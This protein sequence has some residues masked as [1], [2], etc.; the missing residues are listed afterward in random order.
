[1]QRFWNALGGLK[2]F[3]GGGEGWPV[4][5]GGVSLVVPCFA[6]VWVKVTHSVALILWSPASF[7]M[8]SSLVVCLLGGVHS[9]SV[10]GCCQWL[11]LS[12]LLNCMV[13]RLW[14]SGWVRN[15]L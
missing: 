7:A 15:C 4:G 10:G 5:G 2:V 13:P 12:I 8:R 9:C 11:G 1:M 3:V 14:T 6:M